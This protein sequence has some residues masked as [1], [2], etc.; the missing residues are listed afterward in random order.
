MGFGR[1]ALKPTQRFQPLRGGS[2][3]GTFCGFGV[4]LGLAFLFKKQEIQVLGKCLVKLRFEDLN[5][6]FEFDGGHER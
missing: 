4:R 6:F 2:F 1:D 5:P 3:G